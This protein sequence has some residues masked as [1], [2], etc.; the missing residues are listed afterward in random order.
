[1]KLNRTT[2][3]ALGAA[4]LVTGGGVGA[5][6]A[7]E[8]KNLISSKD[9]K[10]ESIQVRDLTAGAREKLQGGDGAAGVAGKDGAAG[11]KGETGATGAAGKDGAAGAKGATGATGAHR[12]QG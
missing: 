9:I 12:C 3:V 10:D 6:S 11:A 8:I 4:I 5:A 1:M 2:A 7:D